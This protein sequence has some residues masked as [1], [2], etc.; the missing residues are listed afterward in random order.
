MAEKLNIL[1]IDDSEDD[2]V[3]YRREL[4][5]RK[6]KSY[7]I[8]EADN[9][10][11]GFKMIK[12]HQPACVLL[13]YSMPG[14]SG[15]EILKR[16]R[17]E[18]PFMPAVMLTGQGDTTLAVDAMKAGAQDYLP[19][20]KITA[21]ILQKAVDNAIEKVNLLHQLHT[22]NETLKE[23][24]QRLHKANEE[25]EAANKAKNEFLANMSHEIRTPMN[26]IIGMSE[27]MLMTELNEKQ[28]KYATAISYSGEMLLSL[29]NDILDFSKIEANEVTLRYVSVNLRNIIN[30]LIQ[31]IEPKIKE[32]NVTIVFNCAENVANSV[33]AD[34]IRIR[35]VIL[36]IINNAI[37]FSRNGNVTVNL[38]QLNQNA[39]GSI[40][41]FEIEDNGVGIPSDKQE[42]IFEKFT[43]VDSSSTRQYGGT[44][45]GLSICKSLVSLM[46][47]SIGVIS[48]LDKGSLF[49]FEITL[50][51]S[52]DSETHISEAGDDSNLNK[53]QI[54]KAKRPSI[55]AK[56]NAKILVAEDSPYNQYIMQRMLEEMGCTVTVAING[57]EALEAMEKKDA[58]Y[59]LVLMDCQMPEMDGYEVTRAARLTSWGKNLPIV[60]VT[61]HAL[62]GDSQKCLDAGMND[63]VSKPFRV[64]DIEK[65]LVKYITKIA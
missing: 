65:I 8:S 1:I 64:I 24:N 19:K 62:Y 56:F 21:E 12:E 46:G 50:P 25:A 40:F 17:T 7:V 22:Q 53:N 47:G 63:Y 41:R 5:K 59:D 49:W 36:N 18:Y 39:D 48:E 37:K 32:N 15:V 61:A 6:D 33:M 10:E 29:V 55:S 23:T 60:A 26:G 27:L 58:H 3:L 34:P 51:I 28:E 14:Q 43:Q 54:I 30:E 9:G 16:I 44:G 20:D 11:S 4:V 2:R 31:I 52:K 42:Y 57:R 45:L 38:K 13:D 35:Q